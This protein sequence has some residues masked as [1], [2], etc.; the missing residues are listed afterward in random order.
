MGD[1][2][3]GSIVTVAIAA[4]V[5]SAAISVS[6][7]RDLCSGPCGIRRGAEDPLG[8]TRSAGHLDRGIRHAP[9]ALAKYGNQE[10][11]T[12]AATRRSGQGANGG[13]QPLRDRA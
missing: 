4:A 7:T 8:R 5:A 13:A 2:F 6:V 12:D 9:A 3:S 10:F 11:F 1:R